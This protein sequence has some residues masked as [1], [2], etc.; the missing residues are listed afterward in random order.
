MLQVVTKEK[1][2]ID[3]HVWFLGFGLLCHHTVSNPITT[4]MHTSASY[5]F[6]LSFLGFEDTT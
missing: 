4:E 5:L 6:F 2:N 1:T 3:L